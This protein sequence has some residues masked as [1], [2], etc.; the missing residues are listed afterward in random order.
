MIIIIITLRGADLKVKSHKD[1]IQRSVTTIFENEIYPKWVALFDL[2]KD[3]FY[4]IEEIK[5]AREII[6]I[7]AKK[8]IMSRKNL[9]KRRK[10]WK[11]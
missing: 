11:V 1:V 10:K 9:N 4:S 6:S 3:F 5:S 7:S 2:I 8:K